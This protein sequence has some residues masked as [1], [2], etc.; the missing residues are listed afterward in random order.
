MVKLYKENPHLKQWVVRI[1]SDN[2]FWGYPT[3][4]FC[5]NLSTWSKVGSPF[6][7]TEKPLSDFG[8]SISFYQYFNTIS[9]FLTRWTGCPRSTDWGKRS[10]SSI[11]NTF[12]LVSRG[13]WRKIMEAG[14]FVHYSYN[15][16][17][18][19]LKCKNAL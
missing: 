12:S 19:T 8:R 7:N 9:T 10:R 13:M 6:Q 15:A 2:I 16:S 11:R 3:C 14:T 17:F 4:V 5:L 18:M 1:L